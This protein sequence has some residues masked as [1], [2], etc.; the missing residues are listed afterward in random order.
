MSFLD[1]KDVCECVS[2]EDD[3]AF[4]AFQAGSPSGLKMIADEHGET[5]ELVLSGD[6]G[7]FTKWLKV[8]APTIRV[9]MQE[10]TKR[11]VLR[12]GEYFLPLVFLAND[13]ALPVYLNLVACYLYEKMKGALKGDTNRVHLSAVFEDR[14]AGVTK[15]F[16]FEGDGVAL[17]NTI[18]KF[19][20]N[21][22]LND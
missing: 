10:P 17:Q 3:S 13:V 7:D 8:G 15:R 22:F 19:D 5:K 21:E 14:T 2:V 4:R 12:S 6:A 16:D 18:K 1:P 11:R 20:L 9:E